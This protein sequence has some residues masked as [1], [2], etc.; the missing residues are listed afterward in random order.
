M[1]SYWPT[2]GQLKCILVYH[3]SIKMYTDLPLVNQNVYWPI[4]CQFKCILRYD[5]SIEMYTGLSLV[6]S[7]VFLN[8]TYYRDHHAKSKSDNKNNMPDRQ[9]DRLTALILKMS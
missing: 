4:I 2:I 6:N 1:T 7:N 3:W 8:S 5:W 9:T